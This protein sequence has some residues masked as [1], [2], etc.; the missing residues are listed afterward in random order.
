MMTFTGISVDDTATYSCN[1]GFELVGSTTATCTQVDVNSATFSPVPPVCKRK[2]CITVVG[3]PSW[4]YGCFVRNFE[5]L[6]TM[7]CFKIN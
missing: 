5:F 7:Q 1:V 3:I 2:C 6:I 4:L